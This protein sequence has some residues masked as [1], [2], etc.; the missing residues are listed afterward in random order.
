MRILVTGSRDWSDAGVLGEALYTVIN[1]SSA[2]EFTIVHGKCPR[3][4][5]QMTTEFCESEA[6]WFDQMG[7]VLAVEPHPAIW[8]SCGHDCPQKP[9]RVLKRPGDVDHPGHLP[10]YCPKAGPRRNR[11]M[12]ARGA[13]VCVAFL[14]RGAANYGTT[15]CVNLA[16]AAGIDVRP[17]T[18]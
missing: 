10:D 12:V 11:A 16:K 8:D 7:Q 3:G 17:W 15:G 4:A 1:D 5:D 18:A 6:V 2:D 9:H 13:D 14:K